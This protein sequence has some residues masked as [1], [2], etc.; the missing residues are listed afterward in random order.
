MNREPCLTA[1]LTVNPSP[2]V[3]LTPIYRGKD[4][5]LLRVDS[6]KGKGL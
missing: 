2:P 5:I 3:I 6:V 4:L 1:T